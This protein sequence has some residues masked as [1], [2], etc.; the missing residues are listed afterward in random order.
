MNKFL[1]SILGMLAAILN[2]LFK[3]FT[4]TIEVVVAQAKKSGRSES[5]FQG[6]ARPI[7]FNFLLGTNWYKEGAGLRTYELY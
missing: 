7:I 1:N 4:N 2:S 3:Y 6:E 5:E